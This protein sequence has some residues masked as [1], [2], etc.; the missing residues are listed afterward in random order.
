MCVR[1]FVGVRAH[2]QRPQGQLLAVAAADLTQAPP[3]MQA[4]SRKLGRNEGSER[5]G[6]VPFFN[7]L[8]GH[9]SQ[10]RPPR[11]YEI[12]E[13]SG[14]FFYFLVTA[15]AW[16]VHVRAQGVVQ[17]QQLTFTTFILCLLD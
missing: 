17:L 8:F 2:A 13:I 14:F 7:C 5:L 4:H 1:A 3:D 9:L 6:M 11:Y 10:K 12:S 16:C 15:V